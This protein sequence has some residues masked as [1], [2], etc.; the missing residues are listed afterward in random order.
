MKK[1]IFIFLI[2]FVFSGCGF[3]TADLNL[4]KSGNEQIKVTEEERQAFEKASRLIGKT[5]QE[6][7]NQF[8]SQMKF[9]NKTVLALNEYMPGYDKL[10]PLLEKN[11]IRKSGMTSYYKVDEVGYYRYDS[12]IPIIMPNQ[13]AVYFYFINSICVY[14]S[15]S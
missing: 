9:S 13:Y 2:C 7:F 4:F 14:V 11:L 6:I 5:K 1:N 3:L 15:G 8:S 10:H 12:G